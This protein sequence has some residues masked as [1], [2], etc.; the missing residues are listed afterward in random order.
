MVVGVAACPWVRASMAASAS[1]CAIAVRRSI[2]AVE[3]RQH[4]LVARPLQHQRVRE[5]VDV[6]G[7]AGEVDELGGLHDFARCPRAARA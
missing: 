7:R 3:R 1:S 4:H 2:D 6:L 5:V